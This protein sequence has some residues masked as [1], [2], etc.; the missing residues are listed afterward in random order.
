LIPLLK[1]IEQGK[2][3]GEGIYNL[4][5]IQKE[6]ELDEDNISEDNINKGNLNKDN[7]KKDNLKYADILELMEEE[8]VTQLNV[9]GFSI[10]DSNY[11]FSS[12]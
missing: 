11:A 12:E 4:T 10:I 3:I 1:E 6:T 7:I 5:Y 8:E 9:D 2:L